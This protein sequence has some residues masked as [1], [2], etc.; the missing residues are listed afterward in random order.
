MA[1]WNKNTIGGDILSGE[2]LYKWDQEEEMKDYMRDKHEPVK[3]LQ[4]KK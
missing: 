4:I 3:R 1:K 2:Q